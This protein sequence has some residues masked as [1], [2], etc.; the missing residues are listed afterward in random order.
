MMPKI[1][2]EIGIRRW[3]RAV[4]QFA[5]LAMI[6]FGGMEAL[7]RKIEAASPT[8]LFLPLVIKSSNT[9][10]L[11]I[12]PANWW[13]PMPSDAIHQELE[14]VNTWSGKGL[15]IA[16]VFHYFDQPKVVN[17]MLAPIWDNG[18]TP[19][20]NIY[21]DTSAVNIASGGW[22]QTIHA[23]AKDFAIFAD[24][25]RRMAFLAPLQEMNW[26]GN[27]YSLDPTNFIKA[28]KRIQSIF[29]QEG[30]P[31]QS[32]RWVFAPNGYSAPGNPPFESYYPGDSYVDVVAF[33]SYN[34]GTYP[35]N[36]YPEWMSPNDVFVPYIQRMIKMAPSKPIFIAQTGTTASGGDKN[37]WLRDAY[38]LL[39]GYSQIKGVIYYNAN[40]DYD[41]AF[42]LP[43]AVVFNGYKDGVANPVYRYISP[44]EARTLIPDTSIF[45]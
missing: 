35:S 26:K 19:F 20:V 28:Y 12:Y 24:G 16:G 36:P 5:A 38:S 18:Y 37:Q 23:W 43:P 1:N 15:S 40:V 42:Y 3:I 9:V 29:A 2:N 14:P 45:P 32:V 34:F 22:D 33:S 13:V 7:P 30:V 8:K 27:P 21:A 6:L 17:M 4:I 10:M 39:A 25:G 11:G 31:A 44:T 41:W